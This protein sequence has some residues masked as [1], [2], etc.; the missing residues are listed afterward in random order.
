MERD[1]DRLAG[2]QRADGGW[3]F[4]HVAHSPAAALD[5]RGHVTVRA[6]AILEANGRLTP[7]AA[8]H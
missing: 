8:R 1:L 4:D 2:E 6:L 5:W 3:D 7:G